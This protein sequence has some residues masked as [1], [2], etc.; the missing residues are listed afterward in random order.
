MPAMSVLAERAASCDDRYA[1]SAAL[2]ALRRLNSGQANSLLVNKLLMPQRWC[3]LT[4][5]SDK[6]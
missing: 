3:S 1:R 4:S 5:S 6:H 2:E